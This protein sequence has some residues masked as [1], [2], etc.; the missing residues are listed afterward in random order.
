MTICSSGRFI[1]PLIG[2]SMGAVAHADF[3]FWEQVASPR[4]PNPLRKASQAAGASSLYR[5][6]D[7]GGPTFTDLRTSLSTLGNSNRLQVIRSSALTQTQI[8][9]ITRFRMATT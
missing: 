6:R 5:G 4:T 2:L 7:Q 8:P 1:A 3:D 9:E